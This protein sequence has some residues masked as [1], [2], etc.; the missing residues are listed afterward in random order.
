M[1]MQQIEC[2]TTFSGWTCP[3]CGAWVP[4]GQTHICYSS[5]DPTVTYNYPCCA[6]FSQLQQ[7]LE[8]LDKLINLMEKRKK[9][10]V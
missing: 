1:A 8:K 5:C 3:Q 10:D 2:E 7:L 6:C 9:K 4:Y